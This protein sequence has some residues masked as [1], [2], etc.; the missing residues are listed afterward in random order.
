M[1]ELP[2]SYFCLLLRFSLA[3]KNQIFVTW[4]LFNHVLHNWLFAGNLKLLVVVDYFTSYFLKWLANVAAKLLQ[5]LFTVLLY[6]FTRICEH[7]LLVFAINLS[8]FVF[9][10]LKK[11]YFVLVHRQIRKMLSKN[12]F[13]ENEVFSEFLTVSNKQ[14]S[15]HG[16]LPQFKCFQGQE[17]PKEWHL[18]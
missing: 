3:E 15:L 8:R 13:W 9:D 2:L 16:W 11:T 6:Y 7:V 12:R 18:V 10:E 14:I 17:F 1:H 4:S 5:L